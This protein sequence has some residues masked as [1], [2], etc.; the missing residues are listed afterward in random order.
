MKDAVM[1]W[2]VDRELESMSEEDRLVVI[3]GEHLV[4]VKY[5]SLL[6]HTIHQQV[7]L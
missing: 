1:A 7:L 6:S 2:S 3:L 4:C 5:N